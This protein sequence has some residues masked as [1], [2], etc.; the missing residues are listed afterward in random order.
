MARRPSK[1]LPP[2]VSGDA[3][4]PVPG[5][6]VTA[7]ASRPAQDGA[8]TSPP[9]IAPSWS[10][11]PSGWLLCIWTYLLCVYPV[12]DTDLWWHLK[13]GE[14]ILAK[15]AVPQVDW[16]TYTDFDKPWIDLHWG[17][18]LVAYGL[19]Q[20]GGLNL[21]ILVKAAIYTAAVAL[22]GQAGFFPVGRATGAPPPIDRAEDPREDLS[23]GWRAAMWIPAV[24]GLSGRA[25]ERP[26]MF[27]LLFLAAVLWILRDAE[28]IPSRLALLPPLFLVW[29]NMHA[30]FA[31]GLVVWVLFGFDHVLRRMLAPRFG[32]R[33][34]A[35]TMTVPRLAAA[36]AGIAVAVLLNPYFLDGAMFP[37]TL[38]E[39]FSTQQAFYAVRVGEFQTPNA[40]FQKAGF[41]SLYFNAQLLTFAIAWG[42]TFLLWTRREFDP[43]RVLSL[44]AYSHLAFEAS[45]NVSPFCLIAGWVASAN[46]CQ[47]WTACAGRTASTS[48]PRA[49]RT[50]AETD[51]PSPPPT[52]ERVV[53]LALVL[54]CVLVV[55]GVWNELGE[56]NKPFALGEAPDWAMHEAA[57]FAAQPGMPRFA[58]VS[59]NGQA[60]VYTYH[61]YPDG[62]VYMDPRL[63]VMTR[64][65][66]ENFEALQEAIAARDFRWMQAI[67]PASGE[68]PAILLDSRYSRPIING[69]LM[70]PGWRLVFADSTGAVFVTDAIADKLR[71]PAVSVEPLLLPP[72]P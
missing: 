55:T 28:R 40:F 33:P 25:L 31:L 57:K 66:F 18:Q 1:P 56:K 5:P 32:L 36:S 15:G 20:L 41:T 62:L 50:P 29:V 16:Y 60:A 10:Q 67:R 64:K 34:A 21:L 49:S 65:T 11:A 54:G 47:W 71:L 2:V 53:S 52:S 44:V 14:Q 45:R 23:S 43:F 61:N 70:T 59:H 8:E 48:L 26:E 17:F 37:L 9:S 46:L 30:L 19:V 3:S 27:S 42:T 22:A 58:F 35:A 69:L 13:T 6:S 12:R 63:E 39:K 7:V 38:W 51:D 68:D 24:I 4:R 72:P